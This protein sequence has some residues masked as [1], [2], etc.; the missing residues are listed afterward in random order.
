MPYFRVHI[1]LYFEGEAED[2]DHARYI[3][4]DI[5]ENADSSDYTVEEFN[6]VTKEWE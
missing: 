6:E 4:D 1:D 3:F 2:S 5:L